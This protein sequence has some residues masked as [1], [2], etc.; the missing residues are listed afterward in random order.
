MQ[1]IYA[2][3]TCS[4]AEILEST[5]AQ[6]ILQGKEEAFLFSSCDRENPCLRNM[7]KK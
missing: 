2:G 7:Q 6:I 3:A 1:C 5:A 4:T